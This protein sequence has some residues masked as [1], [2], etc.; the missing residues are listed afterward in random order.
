MAKIKR[1]I[2]EVKHVASHP[3][4]TILATSGRKPVVQLWALVSPDTEKNYVN[5]AYWELQDKEYWTFG[6]HASDI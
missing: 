3:H 5:E 4:A 1:A 2:T 6:R